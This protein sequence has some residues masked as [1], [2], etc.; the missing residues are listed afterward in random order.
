[1]RTLRVSLAGTVILTLLGGL[2]GTVLAQDGA[3]DLMAPATVT[4]SV[5]YIGGQQSGEIA[6]VD[7]MVRQSGMISNHKWEASDLR[8]SGTE[9]YTKNWDRYPLG[10]DVDATT[11][12]LENDGGRWVGTGVGMEEVSISTDTPLLSTATVILHGEDAYEGLTAYLLLD[13]GTSGSATFAG[14]LFPGEMPP[15]PEPAE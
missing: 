4:G 14:V 13:E 10:F 12:V 7:G 11:R 8:L 5:R 15:F 9:A 6:P 3:A 1:M 2:G